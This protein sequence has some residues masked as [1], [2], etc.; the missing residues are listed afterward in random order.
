MPNEIGQFELKGLDQALNRL[1][2]LPVKM[3]R[4]ILKKAVRAGANVIKDAA[5]KDWR[6]VDDPK[7]PNKIWRF[8][9]TR[10]NSK[11]GR[12]AGGVAFSV[13]IRGGAKKPYKNNA[14][15]QR[16]GRVGKKYQVQ[17][18]VYY[19]RFLE[20]GTK[21]MPARRIFERAFRREL[22]HASDVVAKVLNQGIDEA[23]RKL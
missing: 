22:H 9:A 18:S 12:R 16:K 13:G 17:P 11:Q 14:E 1:R 6:K 3:Q 10:M 20:L 7:T 15:N 5:K 4:T 21:K 19:W 23:M 8:V 2:Q